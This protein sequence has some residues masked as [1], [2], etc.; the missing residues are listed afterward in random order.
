MSLIDIIHSVQWRLEKRGEEMEEDLNQNTLFP[1]EAVM[2][3]V[4]IIEGYNRQKHSL[5]RASCLQILLFS[6]GL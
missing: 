1:A 3:I 5:C 6:G 2:I 4:G